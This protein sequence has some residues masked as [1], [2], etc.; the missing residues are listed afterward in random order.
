MFLSENPDALVNSMWLNLTIH[1]G[2]RGRQEH[3][4]LLWGDVELDRTSDGIEYLVFNERA[5]KTR[6]GVSGTS[7]MFAPKM[8]EQ[9]GDFFY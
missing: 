4:T 3:Q 2:L 8:F 7:R 1:F 9:R 6:N 5:T